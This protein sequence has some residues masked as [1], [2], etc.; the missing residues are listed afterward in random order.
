MNTP[1]VNPYQE[2]VKVDLAFGLKRVARRIRRQPKVM[3]PLTRFVWAEIKAGKK[4]VSQRAIVRQAHS[5]EAAKNA[6]QPVP[7]AQ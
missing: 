1:K 4:R 2:K 6:P 3:G 5:L 7:T